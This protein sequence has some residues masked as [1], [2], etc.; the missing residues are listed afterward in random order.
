MKKE[1][2]EK[3]WLREYAK[4]SSIAFQMIIVILIGVFSGKALD[5]HLE[6]QKP[7]FTMSLT[8]LGLVFALYLLFKNISN[9]S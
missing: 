4:Y 7:V 8:I 5:N 2:Q 9:K 6:N 1:P 3:K